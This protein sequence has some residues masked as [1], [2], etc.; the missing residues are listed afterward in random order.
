MTMRAAVAVRAAAAGHLDDV[1]GAGAFERGDR[2]GLGAERDN[3]EQRGDGGKQNELLA[4]LISP[5][6]CWIQYR[7]QHGSFSNSIVITQALPHEAGLDGEASYG[8]KDQIPINIV[9]YSLA[10]GRT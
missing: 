8:G 2:R 4:H 1:I 10:P 5:G 7:T 9:R 6:S 3:A